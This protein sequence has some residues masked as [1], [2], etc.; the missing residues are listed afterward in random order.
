MKSRAM[1][2]DVERSTVEQ[3]FLELETYKAPNSPADQR[4]GYYVANAANL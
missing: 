2:T 4:C 3:V 1:S